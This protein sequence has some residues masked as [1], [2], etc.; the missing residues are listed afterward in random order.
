MGIGK[1]L[2][3]YK[4]SHRAWMYYELYIKNFKKRI[5]KYHSQHGEDKEIGKFFEKKPQGYYFD[6]GC[7]HPIRYSNTFYLFKKGWSGT[8]IDVNQTSI[9]LFNIARPNDK[10]ICAAIS[11]VS[12]EVDFFE[13][14]ILGPVNTI[15]NKMYKKSKGIFFKKGIVK[16][17]KTSKIFDII[18]ESILH[19]K[20]DFLNIDA[21]G[22]DFK[23]IK[24][25]NLKKSNIS[26]VAIET[27]DPN[28]NKLDDFNNIS[29]YFENNQYFVHKKIGPTTLYIKK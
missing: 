22:S 21:E 29:N 26:L 27:H 23:I 7:F 25:I 3:Q 24:Q 10:N 4:F 19:K 13:D 6:I 8:N 15:E 12:N 16:K 28:G 1:F 11:D 2:K 9:D 14:D 5:K 18:S 20:T 17:I